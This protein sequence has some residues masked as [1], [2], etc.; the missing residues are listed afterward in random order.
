M[1]KSETLIKLEEQGVFYQSSE[2]GWYCGWREDVDL[3]PYLLA[4]GLFEH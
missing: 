2:G 1:I 4:C 3:T